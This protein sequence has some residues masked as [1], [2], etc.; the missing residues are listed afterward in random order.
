MHA[1]TK[2]T[3][4]ILATGVGALVALTGCDQSISVDTSGGDIPPAG[5][6]RGTVNYIGPPPCSQSGHI[7]GN[8]ILLVFDARNPPP[9][10]GLGVTAANFGVVA[11]DVLFHQWPVTQ[12]STKICP[13]PSSAPMTVSAPYVI[14]P[15]SSGQ[16]LIQ[17][18]FDYTGDFFA[19]FKFRQLP[20][21]TDIGGGYI[22]LAAAQQI[23]ANP[24]GPDAGVIENQQNPAYIPTFLPVNVGTAGAT[25]STSLWNVPTFTMPTQ[26]FIADNVSVTIGAP[27]PFS[28]PYF[29]PAGVT[30]A[31]TPLSTITVNNGTGGNGSDTP[32]SAG[33][34]TAQNPSSNVD[35]VPVLSFPQD[36]QVYAQPSPKGVGVGG[37][38]VVDQYQAALPELRLN[39]GMP[40][41][42][43]VVAADIANAA[44]PFHMQLGLTDAPPKGYA[45][46]PGGNG[47]IYVWWN[48]IHTDAECGAKN[49]SLGLEFIPENGLVYRMWPL[50][51]LAKLEDLPAGSQPSSIDQQGLLTQGTDLQKP[52]VIIQGITLYG[53]TFVDTLSGSGGLFPGTGV[54]PPPLLYPDLAGGTNLKDHVSVLV[55][56]SALCLDPRA[57]DN[58]GVLVTTGILQAQGDGSS[59]VIGD[60]PPRGHA[61]QEGR[62]GPGHRLAGA[63]EPPALQ[64]R[65]SQR[66]H[67]RAHGRLPPYWALPDQPR[68][69]H[70]SGVDD[71]ERDRW[72]LCRGGDHA[73]HQRP[74]QVLGRLAAPRLALTR[75]ARR[76]R[77]HAD[78]HARKLHRLEHGRRAH[79]LRVHDPLLGSEPRPDH[80]EAVHSVPRQLAEPEHHPPL[81]GE[82]LK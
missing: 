19:T 49:C 61:G 46:A 60:F 30:P 82:A 24:L 18:F 21:A 57:P 5:V 10:A 3:R 25:P 14:S 22:D 41:G 42:E 20:E 6:I 63:L 76:R 4:F 71:A 15:M 33:V 27:L 31:D 32:P 12:G 36:V 62:P 2:L 28:R 55:R 1:I 44:D 17:A 54:L 9:P 75:D 52:A 34:M 50:V 79:P 65:E 80:R 72:L 7:V 45:F 66:R 51:V 56:P 38:A 69:P 13:D 58:G 67:E 77:D 74:R 59:A 47:G 48:G 40:A 78:D 16:Y 64:A 8:A 39:A 26:G 23:I 68:L 81:H 35:F 11:G 29:Y 73:P 43:Q 37:R 70:R 53:D